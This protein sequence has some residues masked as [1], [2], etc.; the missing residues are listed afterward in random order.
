MKQYNSTT[1]VRTIWSL[2][3]VI[4]ALCL[5]P[6]TAEAQTNAMK[7]GRVDTRKTIQ[8]LLPG[9]GQIDIPISGGTTPYT[10]TLTKYP[11]AYDGQRTT[12]ESSKQK[13]IIYN[14]PKGDYG[15]KISD[16]S[17]N[18]VEKSASVGEISLNTFWPGSATQEFTSPG[19]PRWVSTSLTYLD[20]DR[21]GGYSLSI[22]SLSRYF[23]YAICSLDEYD[24]Y[25]RGGNDLEWIDLTVS[26]STPTYT[27]RYGVYPVQVP[28]YNYDKEQIGTKEKLHLFVQMPD[29]SPSANRQYFDSHWAANYKVG[30][31]M[32]PKGRKDRKYTS[33]THN[34]FFGDKSFDPNHWLELSGGNPDPCGTYTPAVRIK[35]EVAK[36][37]TF[38]VTVLAT[39]KGWTTIELTFTKDNYMIPQVVP[40][41]LAFGQ[42]NRFYMEDSNGKD[43]SFGVK[44]GKTAG[45]EI[46]SPHMSAYGYYPDTEPDKM[47]EDTYGWNP[48]L[49]EDG[50]NAWDY[51]EG[52]VDKVYSLFICEERYG[53]FYKTPLAGAEITLLKAPDGYEAVQNKYKYF[54]KLGETI[55]LS[56][57]HLKSY[58]FPFPNDSA[59]EDNPYEKP[60][61]DVKIPE[62]PYTFRVKYFSCDE[63]HD[64]GSYSSYFSYNAVKYE[65]KNDGKDFKPQY[66][67]VDCKTMRVYPFRGAEYRDILLRNDKPVT[68]Y[69]KARQ[70][71]F[72]QYGY[73]K[74]LGS[75]YVSFNPDDVSQKPEDCYIELRWESS[76]IEIQYNYEN[77]FNSIIPCLNHPT[78]LTVKIEKPTY[79]RDQLYT[80]I[81]P[82]GKTAYVSVLPIRTAGETIVELRD[83]K[84]AAKVYATSKPIALKDQG[85]PVV[86]ELTDDQVQPEYRIYIKTGSGDCALDN[87]D[88]EIIKM[89]DLRGS[90]FI[91]DTNDINY[92]EGDIVKLECPRIRPESKYIWTEPDGTTQ[93]EGRKITIPNATRAI[94]G[95]WKLEVTEVPCDGTPATQTVPFVL[96]VAP[97]ELWWR[98]D[99]TSPNWNS[100]DNWADKEGKPANAI[101]AK[102]TDVHL[103]AVVEKCY[104]NLA[105]DQTIREPLGEPMCNDIYFHFGSALGEPHRLTNYSRAFIDYNFG[106]VQ[107]DGSIKAH[108]DPKHPGAYDR[109]L[110]RD[111][112]YMMATPLKNVYAGDFSLAGYP[113]TYQRYLKVTRVPSSLAEASFDIPMNKQGRLMVAYN[114]ALAYKVE[115]YHPG[116]KGAD[117]HKNLNGLDGII[118]LPYYE[119]KERAPYYPL[120]RY[121]EKWYWYTY[122]EDKKE[123]TVTDSILERRSYFAYFDLNT[124][125]A[126][127]KVDSVKRDPALDYRFLFEND[128]TARIGT[129][130]VVT[131]GTGDVKQEVEGYTLKLNRLSSTRGRGTFVLVGNPFMSPISYE[132]LYNVNQDAKDLIKGLYIFTNGAWRYTEGRKPTGASVIDPTLDVIPPL[133]AFI[134][135]MRS[136]GP[137]LS[138]YFPTAPEHSVLVDP[139]SPEG[140]GAV[141]RN[142]DEESDEI[143]ERY[144]AV[145]VSDDKGGYTSAVLLPEDT[146]ESTPALIAPEGMQTAP[147]V[148]FISPTDSTC[149]F[150]QTNVP[151]AV[152]ELGV[153][154]PT[155]GMLT[156]DFTTLA[157][158]PFDK[159][160]LYDRLRGTEQDL[161]VNPTY[162]YGYSERDGRRFELRMSYGNVRYEEQQDHQADLA[163]ERTATGYRISYDEGIAGYQLYSVY[164]YLLERATTD[165]Q[166]QVDI[167]MPE[168]DVVLLDVQSADGLRWIKKLQR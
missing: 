58:V 77:K 91:T 102:C 36:D 56:T 66:E 24:A 115:G 47:W 128:T 95:E 51:C 43:S 61:F 84:D 5:L 154:A 44:G 166:T 94:S 110:E 26:G 124:L 41:P 64:F 10:I 85:K 145:K 141:L 6:T 98:K 136:S 55:T 67:K 45:G 63:S 69:A 107:P 116:K 164:G 135:Y 137:K 74:P 15:L 50:K 71:T 8:G 161:L 28:V 100:F 62:G 134:I 127:T 152:V 73:E 109:I 27:G 103:P 14:L 138:L 144:V 82:S 37:L 86:F 104:P 133:Q 106:V 38:P 30:I 23:D 165:G 12:F 79:D 48:D 149:N 99:A 119:N 49:I 148:Y 7:V 83:V 32:R 60:C 150:V 126:V 121:Y 88:G 139:N 157:E 155:D 140:K 42:M 9:S 158:K 35:E 111:R 81:C 142:T 143:T 162:S 156:L 31:A 105:L 11:A 117:D 153:F 16:S 20:Y 101:P 80:Y 90:A 19:H 2:L 22:D 168:T 29:G 34:S 131:D 76:T 113:L 132:R 52:T 59:P 21:V 114:H 92:C 112:W 40:E 97:S 4:S 46:L 78:K 129:T 75:G 25:K 93:H 72:D 147:L 17:G 57:K 3:L 160:A 167:E 65:L 163:I 146:E 13:Y 159:L 118:R 39:A 53:V 18:S 130:F 89:S 54:P 87:G 123:G 33:Y 70:V 108:E 151:G 68:I 120:H 125:K 1:L 122:D 96:S